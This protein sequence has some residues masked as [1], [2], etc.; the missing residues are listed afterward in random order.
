MHTKFVGTTPQPSGPDNEPPIILDAAHAELLERLA[1]GVMRTA[2]ELGERL[3]REVAR[4]SVL[5]SDE[6]PGDVV[7]IGSTTTFRDE[8]TGRV[9]TVILVPPTQADIGRH[10][11]SVLTPIG[12]ALIG[13]RAGASISWK[14]RE[15]ETRRLTVTEVRAATA[16]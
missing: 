2:P 14:T 3:M 16:A 8:V 12:A 7:N 6:M 4:A 13:L 5:P 9:Q 15:G 1:S 10:R 11:I